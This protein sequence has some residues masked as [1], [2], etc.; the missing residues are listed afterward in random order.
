MADFAPCPYC[1]FRIPEFSSVCG[2]C[3]REVRWHGG[4][5]YSPEVAEQKRAYSSLI[6]RGWPWKSHSLIAAALLGAR[7]MV[8]PPLEMPW[9]TVFGFVFIF[10][11]MGLLIYPIRWLYVRAK[12]PRN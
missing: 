7:L 3:Q 10:V 2:H 11:L 1:G 6:W 9:E 8:D 5:P 4:W 12:Y